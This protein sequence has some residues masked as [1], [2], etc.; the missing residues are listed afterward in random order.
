ME[1]FTTSAVIY[2]DQ[3]PTP[4]DYSSRSVE[5]SPSHIP[6]YRQRSHSHSAGS[7]P[8]MNDADKTIYNSLG[9]TSSPAGKVQ[10]AVYLLTYKFRVVGC[11]LSCRPG[12]DN[13]GRMLL[14]MKCL[15]SFHFV[16]RTYKDLVLNRGWQKKGTMWKS[17][18][19]LN[20]LPSIEL[21]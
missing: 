16:Q 9:S 10:T 17:G 18:I 8:V 21:F 20:D 6:Q 19:Y 3:R 13:S 7:S 15:I 1:A 14:I 2:S 5:S 4:Q 11:R 12:M